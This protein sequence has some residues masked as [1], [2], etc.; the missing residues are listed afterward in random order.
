MGA[1][2]P[3]AQLY[4]RIY[5][6]NLFPTKS[7]LFSVA[8]TIWCQ[9]RCNSALLWFVC[10]FNTILAPSWPTNLSHESPRV[11]NA[12]VLIC[13]CSADPGSLCW[14][15][16]PLVALY[17]DDHMNLRWWWPF[18]WL[19]G[20]NI[21]VEESVHVWTFSSTSP[22]FVR[23]YQYNHGLPSFTSISQSYWTLLR[24]Q[25]HNRFDNSDFSLSLSSWYACAS[26][27]LLCVKQTR[28]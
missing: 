3:V 8:I 22:F 28:P 7:A 15:T 19:R 21:N 6:P 18:G 25:K 9:H 12:E 20:H 26:P 1:T 17:Y 13:T 2:R 16:V 10:F 23:L 24:I 27:A 14:W 5:L 4:R 11:S